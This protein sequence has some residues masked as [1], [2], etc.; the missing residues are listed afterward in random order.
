MNKITESTAK[1]VWLKNEKKKEECIPWWKQ[2][3][4]QTN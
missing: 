1:K 2:S 4:E 3:L